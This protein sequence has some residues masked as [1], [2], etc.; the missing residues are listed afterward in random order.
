M[1]QK[2]FKEPPIM[3]SINFDGVRL[4]CEKN[5]ISSLKLFGSVLTDDFNDSSDIDI[6]IEFIPNYTPGFFKFIEF[7]S[8]LSQL[9][10]GRKVDLRTK[11][12]LSGYIRQ[13]VLSQA[14]IIYG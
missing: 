1:I 11:S 6:L 8:S 5:H 7:Q 3:K 10:N 2:S 13:K 9:F 12:D 14:V 4:F